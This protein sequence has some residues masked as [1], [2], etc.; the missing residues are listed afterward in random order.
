MTSYMS[1]GSRTGCVDGQ[2]P[3]V[4]KDPVVGYATWALWSGLSTFTPSQHL[5]AVGELRAMGVVGVDW[6]LLTWGT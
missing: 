4:S 6:D 5:Y 3:V 1:C 2:A